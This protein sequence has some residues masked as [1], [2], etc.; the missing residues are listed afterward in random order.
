MAGRF[1][2]LYSLPLPVGAANS[3]AIITQGE[4]LLDRLSEKLFIRVTIK[5]LDEREIHAAQLRLQLFDEVGAPLDSVLDYHFNTLKVKRD[6]EFGRNHLIMIPN[7]NARSFT[8]YITNITFSDYSSWKNDLPFQNFGK[9]QT[10]EEALGNE[11]VAKQFEAQFGNDCRFMPSDEAIIWYCACGA[12]NRSDEDR[13]HLCRRKRTALQDVNFHVLEKEAANQL[14]G[15]E[16]RTKGKKD[17]KKSEIRKTLIRAGMFLLPLVLVVTLLLATI[18]PFLS[19]R[20]T[21][22]QAMQVLNEQK[23]EE[24]QLLFESLGNYQDSKEQVEKEIPYQ[25]AL[26]LMEAANNA[27]L[28]AFSI[29]GLSA[30]AP[31]ESEDNIRMA[32][33]KSAEELLEA[34]SPYKDSD[35]R[36]NQIK[37]FFKV[38]LEKRSEEN[39][40]Y[41]IDLMEKGAYLQARDEFIALGEFK[42]AEEQVNEC[43]YRRATSLLGFCENNNVRNIYLSI[44]ESVDVTTKISMPGSVLTELG[45]DTIYE[46][47]KCFV[48]DGVEFL[49]EDTPSGDKYLPI[50]EALAAEFE[51]LGDYKD[52]Q[53]FK[54]RALTAGDFSQEFYRLLREGELDEA[55]RWLHKYSNDISN[56]DQYIEWLGNLKEL[57]SEWELAIGDSTLIPFS[58][59]KEYTRLEYFTTSIAIEN[60]VATMHFVPD[61]QDYEVM[62]TAEFG[63][64]QFSDEPDGTVYYSYINQVGRLVYIRYSQNGAV[65][66][67]CEYSRR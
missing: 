10:V 11:L 37:E 62:L 14:E 12:V 17:T 67:S 43:L 57:C 19:R 52:S 63:E 23:Y 49:Y 66:S 64:T 45:S 4:L 48:E 24:A 53:D 47:K 34:I 46:L 2:V 65:L 50:C 9:L 58:A 32:L 36:L 59:G 1:I 54:K 44:S 42:D 7:R 27:E 29:V 55:L 30:P 18:P 13:C 38:Q 16:E 21:Y 15:D 8:V 60:N 28:S 39:Y 5:S 20:K 56:S 6:S 35:E 26:F 51:G 40:S 31:D 61:D 3:P 41:A 33:Y 22:Q 25:K